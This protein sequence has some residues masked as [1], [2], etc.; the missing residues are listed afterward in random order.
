MEAEAAVARKNSGRGAFCGLPNPAP[1]P[2]WDQMRSLLAA[3]ICQFYLFIAR[4]PDFCDKKCHILTFCDKR[5]LL[6]SQGPCFTCSV[7]AELQHFILVCSCLPQYPMPCHNINV[8]ISSHDRLSLKAEWE[9]CWRFWT[10][11][12]HSAV[13]YLLWGFDLY[14]LSPASSEQLI[15]IVKLI[16]LSE[17]NYNP[18]DHIYTSFSISYPP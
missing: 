15:I 11:I 2:E 10:T 14:I 17:H 16:T 3:Q 7:A 6:Y 12:I 8:L 9:N 13:R 4:N 1:N 5:P 18:Q